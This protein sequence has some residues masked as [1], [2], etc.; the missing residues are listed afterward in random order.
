LT[1]FER[2]IEPY[3]DHNNNILETDKH[4]D[5]RIAERLIFKRVIELGWTP[6][7]HGDFDKQIG[8]GRGRRD[9]FQERIGK[10]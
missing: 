9:S 8:T 10:K 7:K 4:F 1:E 5:L 6:E 2:D 3:L